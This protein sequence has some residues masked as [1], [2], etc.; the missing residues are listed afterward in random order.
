MTASQAVKDLA[1][2]YARDELAGLPTFR[3]L[4]VDDQR[5][6][7]RDVYSRHVDRL[8]QPPA[9]ARAFAE[10]K[11]AS[12]LIDDQRHLNQRIDQAGNL[13]GDFVDEVD[14]PGFV[15]DLLKGVFDANLKVTLDQ[16]EAYQK[17]LKAA[18]QSLT[19][20]MSKITPESAFGYLA[21]NSSD[22]FGLSF[23]EEETG[24][25]G[26]RKVVLT[27]KEG[28]PVDTEDTKI[29]A[30]IMDAT[31]QMA[32]EQRAMLRETILMGITRLVVEK[33]NVKASVL[34]D[35]KA[36]EQIQKGDKAALEEQVSKSRSITA[37]GGFLGAIFGGPSGGSTHSERKTKL[38]VSSA[39]STANTELAA[40]IT[41]SV[42]ITFKSD[43]FKLDNFAQMY[44][45]IGAAP[46]PGVPGVAAPPALPPAA[47]VAPAAAPGVR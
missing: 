33:G 12:D 37:S 41:G 46:P 34:F 40:K 24:V 22:E 18:T 43:Y 36:G 32:R 29:K 39:K 38:S 26:N 9:R 35:I 3:Q 15:K 7:Y 20:F 10:P 2:S 44:G 19:A 17:L 11:K 47:G 8:T 27:D 45:P 5:A 28:N 1:R 23:S 14:F 30:K 16:M 21:E 42:D 4:G 13:A 31:L 25:D 6:L